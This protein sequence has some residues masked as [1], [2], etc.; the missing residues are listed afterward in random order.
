V[1]VPVASTEESAYAGKDINMKDVF[2]ITNHYIDIMIDKATQSFATWC[3]KREL[4]MLIKDIISFIPDHQ[5]HI[6]GLKEQKI[7]IIHYVRKSPGNEK[8]KPRTQ[9]LEQ[10]IICLINYLSATDEDVCLVVIHY[11]GLSTNVDDLIN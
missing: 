3:K 8:E 11:A 2:A 10:Q 4:L 5:K 1:L 6:K 9:M 7:S